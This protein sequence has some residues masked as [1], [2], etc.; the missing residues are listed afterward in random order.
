MFQVFIYI[1]GECY[2]F[3]V[4]NV[5]KEEVIMREIIYLFCIE[6]M[7]YSVIVKNLFENENNEIGLENVIN[8]VVIFKKLGVLGY[9]V[10]ELK[11]ELLKDFNM[12]FYYY[13]KIQYSKVEYM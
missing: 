7:L 1:V 8:K 3:G 5:I 12:Y 6:F 13:F 9:G 2:V 11:D 4:G 10:Y